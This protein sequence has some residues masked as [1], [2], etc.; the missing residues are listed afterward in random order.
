MT[1]EDLKEG[2]KV[3]I[4]DDLKYGECYGDIHYVK[5]M[6]FGEHTIYDIC[7]DRTFTI[8][9][10]SLNLYTPEMVDWKRTEELNRT[11]ED[12]DEAAKE[13]LSIP[14]KAD[15][16]KPNHYKL[17]INGN[18]CEVRDVMQAVMT[19]EEYDGCSLDE[20]IKDFEDALQEQ[21]TINVIEAVIR[22]M[23]DDDD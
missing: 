12:M 23:G 11:L 19:A 21:Y 15:A 22:A 1:F 10:D 2:M 17:Q 18:E 6:H 3:Y 5:G 13:I 14:D 16:I 9:F 8:G 4:K 7:E 20:R